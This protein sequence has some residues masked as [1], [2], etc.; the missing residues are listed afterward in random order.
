MRIR[1]CRLID[2]EIR[3]DRLIRRTQTVY[4]FGCSI[5]HHLIAFLVPQVPV[6][7]YYESLC[8]DSARFIVDQL[9][10]TK[11]SPLGR[12]MDVILIPFGKA[13]VSTLQQMHINS[14]CKWRPIEVTA[15]IIQAQCILCIRLGLWRWFSVVNLRHN[16]KQSIQSISNSFCLFSVE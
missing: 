5:F 10:P 12:F 13:S 7:V 6:T 3:F 8:P 9:H 2:D 4:S 11:L 1:F 15:I 14:Q 16:D